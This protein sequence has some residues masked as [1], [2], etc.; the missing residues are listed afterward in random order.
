MQPTAEEDTV[1]IVVADASG[2]IRQWSPGASRLCGHLPEDGLGSSLDV[3]VPEPYRQA[4]W[5]AFAAVMAGGPGNLDGACANIPVVVTT[6]RYGPSL[7]G[8]ASCAIRTDA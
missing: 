7:A 2:T 8:S 5:A 4:H 3:I 6:G 1:A